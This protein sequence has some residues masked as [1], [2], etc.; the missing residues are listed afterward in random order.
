MLFAQ[1]FPIA[2]TMIKLQSFPM[3]FWEHKWTRYTSIIASKKQ[4]ITGMKKWFHSTSTHSLGH[5]AM[6]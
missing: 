3:A 5:I 6:Q 2:A 4:L 1:N